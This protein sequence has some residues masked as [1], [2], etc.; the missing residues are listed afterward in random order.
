MRVAV[1]V[2]FFLFSTAC[3]ELLI[4]ITSLVAGC[5]ANCSIHILFTI[6]FGFFFDNLLTKAKK[7]DIIYM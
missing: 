3:A 5:P 4:P 7:C 2:Y 1:S 6:L